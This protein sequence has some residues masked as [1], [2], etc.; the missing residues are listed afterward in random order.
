M[1]KNEL[2]QYVGITV[3]VVVAYILCRLLGLNKNAFVIKFIMLTLITILFVNLL[4]S[5]L[6]QS[7]EGRSISIIIWIGLIMR[8]GYMLYTDCDV[9]G[10]DL[11]EID[12]DAKGHAGYILTLMEKHQ[13]PES[14]TLQFYQAPFFYILGALFSN[15]INWILNT[16]ELFYLV[17]AAKTVSCVASCI[18]LFVCKKV[19]EECNMS[20]KEQRFALM[21]TTFLP[22]AYLTGGGVNPDAL[23]S[24]FMMLAFLYT[25]R[26]MKCPS[27]KNTVILAIIYGFGVMT[28]ISCAVVAPMTAILFLRTLYREVKKENAKQIVLK[29]FVFA[30]ISLPLGL[31][32]SIRN[33]VLFQQPLNYVLELPES[34]SLYT[35]MHS[36]PQ[37]LFGVDV[38]NLIHSPYVNLLD[39]YNA[40]A[41]YLK[42]SLF[43]EF[44]YNV[45]GWIP[46]LLLLCATIISIV[47]VIS[48][49]WQLVKNRKDEKGTISVLLF[50]LFYGSV[51]YFYYQYP[52][53]CSM[54]FRYM[55]F[56]VIPISVVLGKYV[57]SHQEI[58][59]W[60]NVALWGGAM[61]SC[62]MYCII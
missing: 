26:F 7:D 55:I 47:A 20:L 11:W 32:Y 6:K 10:H 16:E 60:V 15:V 35:G 40:P 59:R 46:V 30:I 61:S 14:N 37:R 27:W 5:S 58:S 28:K 45:P 41:Y 31:W 25:L 48:M 62:L 8:I 56:C 54:D 2:L 51:L 24:M 4:V 42:S 21:V 18:S 22:A 50:L 23:A 12:I 36:I 49:I 1:K 19:Y 39:D 57:I 17:D 38:S 33:Y 52:F 44:S 3:L 29:Y 53:S 34:I 43:G 9:R 13:L